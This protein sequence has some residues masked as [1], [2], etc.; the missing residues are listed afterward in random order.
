M[1]I[2][3]RTYEDRDIPEMIDIWNQVVLDGED[4][5]TY[6]VPAMP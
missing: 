2:I 3:V 5:G 4:A 6:A 1:D